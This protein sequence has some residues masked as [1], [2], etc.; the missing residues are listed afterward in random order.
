MTHLFRELRRREARGEPVRTAVIGA[1]FMG[2]GLVYQLSKMPGM[3]PSLVVNRSP[4]KAITAYIESG[5]RKQDILISDDPAKLAAAV[6][7]NRP[8]VSTEP[9]IAGKVPTLDV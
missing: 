6:A 9:E 1:G 2:K 5:F 8:A 3:R 7:E 4:E